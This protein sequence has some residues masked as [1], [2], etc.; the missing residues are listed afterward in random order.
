MQLKKNLRFSILILFLPIMVKAN[1][2]DSVKVYIENHPEIQFKEVVFKQFCFET[3]HFKSK[4]FTKY[5]N[6]A[7]IKYNKKG[8]CNG[9]V[10][11]Y[12]KYDDW[13]CSIDDY[14]RIQKRI[15]TKYKACTNTQYI[16][17]LRKYGY[18]KD[19]YFKKLK[20]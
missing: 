5:N 10:K 3:G 17:S 2:K 13:K 11:G 9:K 18:A 1:I 6:I 7:G 12:A 19:N 4:L 20:V 16:I 8:Y 14:I 15:L